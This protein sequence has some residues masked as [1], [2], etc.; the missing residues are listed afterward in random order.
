M[1]QVF[2]ILK[3]L[4]ARL[5]PANHLIASSRQIDGNKTKRRSFHP[6]AGL[7]IQDTQ[8]HNA[9][10][11]QSSTMKMK[12]VIPALYLAA[13]YLT[14]TCFV[15]KSPTTSLRTSTRFSSFTRIDS[16]V[17]GDPAGSSTKKA[18]SS[19]SLSRPK[20]V[21]VAG[22]ESFNR[23]LYQSLNDLNID[24]TVFA[25]S[26]IRKATNTTSMDPNDLKINPVFAKAVREADAFV[27]SLIFDYDDVLA[28]QALLADVQG[29]RFIFESATELMEF[30]EVGSF[31]M[32]PGKDGPS[33][34]PPA[35][36]AVLSK[37]GSGKEEDKLAGYLKL[38]KVGPDLLKLVPGDKATD[39]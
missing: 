14:A 21:L 10:V 31:S 13:S 11:V 39:L 3:R 16:A 33:G 12:S 35:V 26:D 24:L 27:G 2:K 29:P 15:L 17:L 28:V 38:L 6:A 18:S 23:D 5:R 22:F 9:E 36:K 37:F 20:V 8:I 4:P 25:D 32:K 7:A 19:S 1:E 34:P 30:N